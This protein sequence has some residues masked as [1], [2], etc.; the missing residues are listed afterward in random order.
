MVQSRQL[1]FL[2]LVLAIIFA[3]P[4]SLSCE[5]GGGDDSPATPGQPSD[6]D[7]ASDDDATDDDTTD[8]DTADDDTA[9][10]DTADDDTGDDDTADDDTADDDTADDDTAD[11]DTADD[12]T[13]DDD[14]FELDFEDY[15]LGPL[16]VPPWDI[17]SYG[18]TTLTVATL[19]VD[20]GS[21]K[22]LKLDGGK[23][24]GDEIIGRFISTDVAD[25]FRLGF[26]LMIPASDT[27]F[28]FHVLRHWTGFFVAEAVITGD[29]TSLSATDFDDP[30]TEIGCGTLAAG[31]WHTVL[32]EM[33]FP[34]GTYDV[35]LDGVPG[36]CDNLLQQFG[37]QSAYCGFAVLDLADPDKGGVVWFDN[38]DG[39]AG[40][41]VL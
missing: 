11:D 7:A 12:D 6:D 19:P 23:A 29:G 37:D 35:V 18:A 24:N 39:E 5:S 41:P 28:Q 25:D 38:I 30:A 26:E 10:D 20:D 27:S 31:T 16:P 8:D 17:Y 36:G 22:A 34:N 13:A 21:G 4:F 2:A 14:V 9:D 15:A 33:D 1:G 40:A 32:V 3:L